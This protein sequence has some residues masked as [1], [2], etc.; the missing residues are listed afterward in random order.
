MRAAIFVRHLEP[1]PRIAGN[2]GFVENGG[3][4]DAEAWIDQAREV[5]ATNCNLQISGSTGGVVDGR[6]IS[7][8]EFDRNDVAWIVVVFPELQ[9]G[10]CEVTFASAGQPAWKCLY[11][12]PGAL[13]SG[14]PCRSLPDAE[15]QFSETCDQRENWCR[16]NGDAYAESFARVR[17]ILDSDLEYFT[18]G[19]LNGFDLCPRAARFL[20][21]ANALP[22]LWGMG[23]YVDRAHPLNGEFEELLRGLKRARIHAF[24]WIAN[25]AYSG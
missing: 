24:E 2:L 4:I 6:R 13:P 14:E 23:S 11:F 1:I 17:S 9:E 8:T 18:D 10:W 3:L 21:A 25:T 7:F 20:K 22:A 5:G 12:R 16:A 15:L 19:I